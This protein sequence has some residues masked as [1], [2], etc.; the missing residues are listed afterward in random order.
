[1]IHYDPWWNLAVEQ[2]ATDRAHRIGQTRA[3]TVY[4]LIAKDTVE[5]RIVALQDTKRD[6]AEGI[7]SG[8][9]VSLKDLSKEDLMELIGS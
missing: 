7:L 2:Q 4:K 9:G 1:M 8:E 6:L 5:E 3:V